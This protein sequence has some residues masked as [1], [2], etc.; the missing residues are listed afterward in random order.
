MTGVDAGVA[1]IEARVA[2]V[3]GTERRW[4]HIVTAPPDLDLRFPVLRHGLR[5]VESLQRAIVPL[6]EPPGAL[7]RDPHAVQLVEH[8]PQRADGAL[9]HRGEGN[10]GAEVLLDELLAGLDRFESALRRQ[11]D[12]RPAGEQ[13]LDVPDAL[14]VAD[15]NQLSGHSRSFGGSG[16]LVSWRACVWTRPQP[17]VWRS[18]PLPRRASPRSCAASE[19]TPCRRTRSRR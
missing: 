13:I 6:V 17:S 11:I 14:A 18:R 12:I 9:Q 5:L 3:V 8:D 2:R 4:R 1:L 19:R 10:V 7:D 15:Q 16:R